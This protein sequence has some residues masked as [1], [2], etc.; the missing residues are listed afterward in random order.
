MNSILFTPE[1]LQHLV[2]EFVLAYETFIVNPSVCESVRKIKDVTNLI[3]SLTIQFPTETC[4][5]TAM[6]IL[7]PF[8]AI[9][10]ILL[11]DGRIH[12]RFEKS[13][14]ECCVP[15]GSFDEKNKYAATNKNTMTLSEI[16]GGKRKASKHSKPRRSRAAK[17]ARRSRGSKRSTRRKSR[18]SR[19]SRKSRRSRKS[20]GSRRRLSKYNKFV[21]A[22]FHE[23]DGA[24]AKQKLK[25]VAKLWRSR[26]KRS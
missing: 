19:G 7:Y 14:V 21:K 10:H 13:I 9:N 23:V 18:R 2:N 15:G 22:H 12:P 24:S 17:R 5:P 16:S 1:L 3:Y 26:S 11:N 8:R 6:E 4:T 20:R 25:N